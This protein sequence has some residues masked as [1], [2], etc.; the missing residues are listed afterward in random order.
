VKVTP[1]MVRRRVRYQGRV[2]G[3]G[4]RATSRRVA[5]QFQVTGFVRNEPNGTVLL[6]AEG[7][8]SEVDHFLAA[9]QTTLGRFV[10]GHDL[11]DEP[12]TGEWDF[13]EIQS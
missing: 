11:R 9:I 4:F 6:V 1:E 7:A 10:T 2:Q 5:E 8:G 3:V 13:F 12:P